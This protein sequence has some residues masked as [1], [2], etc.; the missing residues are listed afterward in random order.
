MVDFFDQIE[1]KVNKLNSALKKYN[2]IF[3]GLIV[4]GDLPA[5]YALFTICSMQELNFHKVCAY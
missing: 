3:K 2:K 4:A 1:L 5:D